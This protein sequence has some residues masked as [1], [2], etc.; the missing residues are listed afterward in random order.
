MKPTERQWFVITGPDDVGA[1]FASW[2]EAREHLRTLK[3]DARIIGPGCDPEGGFP[4]YGYP[5]SLFD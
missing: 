3:E 2:A 5:V 4:E 1:E